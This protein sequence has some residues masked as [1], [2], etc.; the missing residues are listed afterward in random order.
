M[1]QP[2]LET[3]K[4]D[5]ATLVTP[6]DPTKRHT[7]S[8]CHYQIAEND[9]SLLTEFPCNVRAFQNEVFHLWR[10]PQCQNIHCLEIVD[11][12][13]YYIRSQ[14]QR[15]SP[16]LPAPALRTSSNASSAM[17]SPDRSPCWIMAVVMAYSS[18]I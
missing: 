12:D 18:N 10:C 16:I 4:P 7:C 15:P 2:R 11:L 6:C 3:L 17:V 5:G 1:N 8:V 13:R 9:P 14:R